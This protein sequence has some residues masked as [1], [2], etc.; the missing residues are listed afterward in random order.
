MRIKSKKPL[1]LYLIMKKM[2][3][4]NHFLFLLLINRHMFFIQYQPNTNNKSHTSNHY[5]NNVTVNISLFTYRV[6]FI[7]AANF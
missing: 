5:Y 7:K 4:N 6:N 1:I 3:I 2:N